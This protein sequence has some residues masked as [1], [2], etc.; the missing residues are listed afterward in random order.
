MT[1]SKAI[2]A[3]ALWVAMIAPLGVTTVTSESSAS[4]VYN[5]DEPELPGIEERIGPNDWMIIDDD[6]IPGMRVNELP[7]PPVPPMPSRLKDTEATPEPVESCTEPTSDEKICWSAANDPRSTDQRSRLIDPQPQP[8]WDI[9]INFPQWCGSAEMPSDQLVTRTQ[10]CNVDFIFVTLSRYR[11]GTWV[12]TGTAYLGAMT[13]TYTSTTLNNW[14]SSLS[15]FLVSAT[16]SGVG[17]KAFGLPDCSDTCTVGNH[18]F[19]Q[20]SVL[21]TQSAR[22][23]AFLS[24]DPER[25]QAVT[26]N[27]NW[28]IRIDSAS[29]ASGG[30]AYLTDRARVRCDDMVAGKRSGC[31]IA[32]S[33]PEVMYD[34]AVVDEFAA[35]VT[36][37]QESN[38]PGSR[39]SR[40]P[41][42]RMTDAKAADSNRTSVCKR[43]FVRPP[44]KTCDEYPFASTYEGGISEFDPGR[45][46]EFCSISEYPTGVTDWYG[47]SACMI[48][49]PQ[50]AAAGRFLRA[51]LYT[52][53]RMLDA[54]QFYVGVE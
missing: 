9:P 37:A 51:K 12:E 30:T 47:A 53:Y 29:G 43:S 20:Q 14:S 48:D 19:P 23:I 2:I 27:V 50:N 31:V 40:N 1:Y 4:T 16:G 13:Y 54:D 11:N 3:T 24:M 6:P 22:G 44:G 38:L 35:H 32:D 52:P 26:T 8:D 25:G 17:L 18:T 46:F 41:L 5:E 49:G 42:S 34:A 28:N 39:Q 7:Y 45:T 36:A 15:I 21:P 33:V 10:Y